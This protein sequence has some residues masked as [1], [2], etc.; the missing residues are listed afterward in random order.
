M[1]K[2]STTYKLL[3]RL[4]QLLNIILKPYLRVING[5]KRARLFSE[6]GIH[7]D[8]DISADLIVKY[9]MNLSIGKNVRIGPN[10]QIG[11]ASQVIIGDEVT[12][13]EGVTIETAGLNTRTTQR[14]HTSKPI[15]VGNGA[16]IGTKA[17]IL[18]GAQI[19]SRSIVSAGS[20]VKG[21][22]PAGHI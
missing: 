12:L 4:V 1:N 21:V 20:I 6:I 22:V 18:G 5:L 10:C 15:T 13:S 11:A 17:I 3:V 16:W 2:K 9:P 8:S 14:R 19:G 7:S